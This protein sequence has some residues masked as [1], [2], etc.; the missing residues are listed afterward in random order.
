[1]NRLG[2]NATLLAIGLLVLA[3]ITVL[4]VAVLL[5]LYIVFEEAPLSDAILGG[6]VGFIGG[7]GV[8][9]SV[10][11]LLQSVYKGDDNG[12]NSARNRK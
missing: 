2:N 8:A 9:M 5:G 7:N 6:L 4:S 10:G 12:N 11:G 1:M 3:G